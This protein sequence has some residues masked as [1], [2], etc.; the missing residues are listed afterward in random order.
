MIKAVCAEKAPKLL[1]SRLEPDR[2]I[3]P[4]LHV[5]SADSGNM[6][7]SGWCL[8]VWDKGSELKAGIPGDELV[9]P[10]CLAWCGSSWLHL[11]LILPGHQL[12]PCTCLSPG[13][14]HGLS[15]TRQVSMDVCL[16][17]SSLPHPLHPLKRKHCKGSKNGWCLALR[18]HPEPQHSE[19]GW[20][21]AHLLH[22][23]GDRSSLPYK[24]GPAHCYAPS[25]GGREGSSSV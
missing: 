24:K 20:G 22:G 12:L 17:P 10:D 6:A 3:I 4:G 8:W 2:F 21:N 9:S 7:R 11:H 25:W 23:N 13:L 14:S 19:A 1:F 16:L 5:P 18:R 15:V